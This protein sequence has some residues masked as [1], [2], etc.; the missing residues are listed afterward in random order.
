[1]GVKKCKGCGLGFEPSRPM[2]S[3]C[4]PVCALEHT[5]NKSKAS[6]EKKQRAKTRTARELLKTRSDF[7][8][9][10]QTEFNKFIR[11]RDEGLPCISCDKPDNGQHQRHAS[12]YRSSG[13]NPVLRFDEDNCHSS[14]ST[15]NSHLSGNLIEY[16]IRL[17][18]KRGQSV[19]DRLEGPQ[20]PAKWTIEGIKAIKAKYRQLT[21]DLAKEQ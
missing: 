11:L 5:R 15:C 1:M 13:N 8:K 7:L 3:V 19:V 4:S 9:E 16:R 14:C 20:P 12:H 6:K 21:K 17:I 18:K 10:A 2:Q